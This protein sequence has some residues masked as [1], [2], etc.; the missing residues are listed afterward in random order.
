MKRNKTKLYTSLSF[1]VAFVIWTLL[2]SFIDVSP[3][4]PNES[5]VGFATINSFVHGLTG[6]NMLLYLITDWLGLVPIIVALGFAILGLIQLIKRKSIAKVDESI[7]ILGIFYIVVIVMYILFE[8]IIINYRPILI[9]G[10]LEASYPSS[11]TMLVLTVMLTAI[12]QVKLRT[13]SKTV[14]LLIVF[15]ISA[16]IAFMVIGRFLSGVHW[17]TDIIGGAI[18]S[19]GLVTMYQYFAIKK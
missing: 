8:Y 12:T 5:K 1:L 14:K 11:T 17:L 4:G 19:V 18:L 6:T 3:I 15:S 7:L 13:K 10:Y 9:N 2:I 16:F